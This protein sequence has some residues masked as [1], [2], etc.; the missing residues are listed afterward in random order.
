[1]SCFDRFNDS[2]E[3]LIGNICLWSS[4]GSKQR[5]LMFETSTSFFS[6]LINETILEVYGNDS[7]LYVK[8]VYYDKINYYRIIHETGKKVMEIKKV[9][10]VGYQKGISNKLKRLFVKTDTKLSS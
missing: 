3:F 4:G 7:V 9:D 5:P 1:M 10:L 8:S 2:P 6:P